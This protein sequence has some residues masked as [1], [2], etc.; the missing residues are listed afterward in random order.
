MAVRVENIF[1]DLPKPSGQEQF[2]TL[3]ENEAV[4]IERIVSKSHSSPI[5][6]WYDQCRF[7]PHYLETPAEVINASIKAAKSSKGMMTNEKNLRACLSS[8]VI[9]VSRVPNSRFIACTPSISPMLVPNST[10]G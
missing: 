10:A 1:A 6:F 5:G 9:V 2:L 7:I 4:R 8:P 3:F